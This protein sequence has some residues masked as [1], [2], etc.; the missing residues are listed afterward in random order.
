MPKVIRRDRGKEDI[1]KDLSKMKKRR[2]I[3]EVY[4][5]LVQSG[6]SILRKVN[7]VFRPIAMERERCTLSFSLFFY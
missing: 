5:T 3:L 6:F 2:I 7:G 4:F 1:L